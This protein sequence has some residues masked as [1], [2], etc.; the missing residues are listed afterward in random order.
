[1]IW[2]QSKGVLIFKK[3]NFGKES[4]QEKF[5]INYAKAMNTCVIDC[6]K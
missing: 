5:T 2:K 3:W 6:L 1:M 4:S